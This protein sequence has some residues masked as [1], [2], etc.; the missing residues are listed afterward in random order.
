MQHSL[1]DREAGMPFL[2]IDQF[3]AE[4]PVPARDGGRLR[5]MVGVKMRRFRPALNVCAPM[6]VGLVV[7]G[8]AIIDASSRELSETGRPYP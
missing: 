7:G 2:F 8:A 3:V 5:I 6:A 4:A 1:Y